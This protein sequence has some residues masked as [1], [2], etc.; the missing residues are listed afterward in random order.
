MKQN[1]KYLFL[2][3]IA[4]SS[5]SLFSQKKEAFRLPGQFYIEDS[6]SVFWTHFPNPFSFPTIHEPVDYDTVVSSNCHSFSFYCELSDTVLVVIRNE[7]DS[8]YYQKNVITNYPPYFGFCLGSAG[9]KVIF[10][11]L[12][13]HKSFCY[14]DHNYKIFLVVNNREKCYKDFNFT[15]RYIWI[16]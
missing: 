6:S 10:D 8:V 9:S 14:V 15:N 7:S 1:Y 11:K 16:E 4:F 13:E 12:P 3:I 2:F 5:S